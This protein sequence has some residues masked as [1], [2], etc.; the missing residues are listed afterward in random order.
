MRILEKDRQIADCDREIHSHM[1]IVKDIFL[2]NITSLDISFYSSNQHT[3][4]SLTLLHG[5]PPVAKSK[6]DNDAA[7]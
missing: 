6:D 3:L 2:S 4:V 1:K 7:I 5:D